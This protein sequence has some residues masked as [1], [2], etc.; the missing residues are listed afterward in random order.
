M[1]SVEKRDT[2]MVSVENG[3]RNG[4]ASDTPE[5]IGAV[6][7]AVTFRSPDTVTGGKAAFWIFGND[8]IVTV[9]FGDP[10]QSIFSKKYKTRFTVSED[11]RAL[12]ISPLRME[13]AGTYSVT[14]D[15]EKST[16]TL[17]VYREL[18]EPT[19]TCEAQN[20]SDGICNFSLSCSVSGAGFGDISYT[21][22]GWDQR[23]EGQSLGFPVNKSSLDELEPLMCT[24]QNAV[25]IGSVTVTNPGG[26]CPE[27]STHPPDPGALSGSGVEIWVLVGV[28]VVVILVLFLIFFSKSR[29]WRK[30]HL[31][32]SKPSH[33]ATTVYA[34][35]GLSHQH[36]KNPFIPPFF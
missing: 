22:R 30:F 29:G 31:S 3:H 1:V 35:V 6:G 12:S 33:P 4:S 36:F 24:A 16:F 23:W 5:L 14:I 20:C 8:P 15:E 27:I 18:P 11:G 9:L 25:S 2:G 34:E 17:Q 26:L 28:A 13:D 32:Q 7:G 21:W 19:V 10:S